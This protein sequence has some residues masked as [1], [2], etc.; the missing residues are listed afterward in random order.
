MLQCLDCSDCR[1]EAQMRVTTEHSPANMYADALNFYNRFSCFKKP[2]C[3]LVP[4]VIEVQD[5][6]LE[7][8][9]SASKCGTDRFGLKWRDSPS[10]LLFSANEFRHFV[11]VP[12]SAKQL[13][14]CWVFVFRKMPVGVFLS[15]SSSNTLAI[16]HC[17]RAQW[18]ANHTLS[19]TGRLEHPRYFRRKCAVRY[20]SSNRDG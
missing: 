9:A 8:S 11:R 1:F 18:I 14:V 2:D 13:P 12:I 4:Q 7:N 20:A 16:K 15:L 5:L 10:I 6:F 19:L 17:R 3:R